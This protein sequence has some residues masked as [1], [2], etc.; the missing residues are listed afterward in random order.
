MPSFE[1]KG[2]TAEASLR[3]ASCSPT[4]AT[5]AVAVLRRQQIQITQDP[6]EGEGDP[7]APEGAAQGQPQAARHLHPPVLGDARRRP[8]ARAVPGDPRRARRRTA[9]SATIINQVRGDVEAGSSLADAMRKHPKAFDNLYVNMVAAGEAGGILDI[10]LQRLVDLHREGGQAERAGQVGP[11]V[12]GR[13]HRD[14][15]RRRVHHPV[16]GHPGLRPA[17]RRPGRRAAPA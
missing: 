14:R 5:R 13:G 7:A 8:A 3:R 15:C 2:R 16:E 9:T 11:D 6:G 1:W 4:R 10:I 12:P 17:V